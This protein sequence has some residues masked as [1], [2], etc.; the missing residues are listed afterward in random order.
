[1]TIQ[2]KH[3]MTVAEFV[4]W[5]GRQGGGRFELVRGTVVAMAPE[6]ARHNLVKLAVAR[7]LQDAVRRSGVACTVFTDGMTV[8]IDDETAREPDA[9]IQCGSVVDLDSIV[10]DQPVLVVEVV[11]P[12]SER[13]DTGSKL[14]DY[15]SVPTIVHYL[16]IDPVRPTVVHHK[17]GEGGDI[18]TTIHSGGYIRL[19]LPGLEVALLDLIG[20]E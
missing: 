17:R 7:S 2:P 5:V 1:M 3:R 10:I 20:R 15:F 8:K 16:I 18:R 4:P 6:R 12:S 9:A 11:S 13:E 14:A 19:D